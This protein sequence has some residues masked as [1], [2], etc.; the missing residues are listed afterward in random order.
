MFRTL[1]TCF[2][3]IKNYFSLVWTGH[4]KYNLHLFSLF[5][6]LSLHDQCTYLKPLFCHNFVC[7]LT[8]IFLKISAEISEKGPWF[9]RCFHSCP[10]NSYIYFAIWS[11]FTFSTVYFDFSL[12]HIDHS[13]IWLCYL[14]AHCSRWT[15]LYSI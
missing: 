7:M 9:S 11:S 1:L 13:A 4:L 14:L 6:W 15:L 10:V 3:I 2:F 5:C 12:N 8:Y